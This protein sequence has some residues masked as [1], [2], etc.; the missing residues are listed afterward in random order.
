MGLPTES[1]GEKSPGL[2]LRGP[3]V[4][5]QVGSKGDASKR[6]REETTERQASG[7]SR[8]Q[9]KRVHGGERSASRSVYLVL[10][11]NEKQPPNHVYPLPSPCS[12][13]RV[14]TTMDLEMQQAPDEVHPRGAERCRSRS[15]NYFSSGCF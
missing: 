2:S 4:C 1:A 3:K 12:H 15:C 9:E 10:R 8:R 11:L 6:A 7:G 5:S 14:Q 13:H